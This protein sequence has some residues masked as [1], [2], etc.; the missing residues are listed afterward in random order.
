[1][2]RPRTCARRWSPTARCSRSSSGRTTRSTRDRLP[3]RRPLLLLEMALRELDGRAEAQQP[4]AER[5][6]H[7]REPGPAQS[8]A[9]EDVAEPVQAEQDARRRD[10]ARDRD[11][12]AGEP[13]L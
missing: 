13:D 7:E 2:R 8:E 4:A 6:R 3:G 9:A 10:R 12:G 11:R 1:G 5:E